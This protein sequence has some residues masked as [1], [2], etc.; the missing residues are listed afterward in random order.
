MSVKD[1]K[2]EARERLKNR[3]LRAYRISII[4]GSI[5]VL[6]ALIAFTLQQFIPDFPTKDLTLSAIQAALFLVS[7][8]LLGSIRQGRTA[9]FLCA[10]CGKDPSALQFRFWLRRGRGFRA[11]WLHTN[12]LARKGLR[13]AAMCAPGATILV[14]GV[15]YPEW[16]TKSILYASRIGGT[17]CLMIGILFAGL[18][19]Q[20]YALAQILF[21][22]SPKKSVRSAIRGSCS[23]MEDSCMR[24][25]HAKLSFIPWFAACIG[26]LPIVFVVPYYQQTTACVLRDILR[27]KTI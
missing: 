13:I 24:L 11:A 8:S 2:K 25:L 4:R 9:W 21:A 7:V 22:R 17:L 19:N 26:I 5:T 3:T 12:I 20:E 16:Q 15:L 14:C 27:A 23:L 18:I 10:S 1:Y 6:F